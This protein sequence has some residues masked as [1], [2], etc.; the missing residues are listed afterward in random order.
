MGLSDPFSTTYEGARQ[1][2]GTIGG[3]FQQ[4]AQNI[5]ERK[6]KDR[7]FQQKAQL[8]EQEARIKQQYPSPWEAMMMASLPK[9]EQ[10]NVNLAGL[11]GP[12]GMKTSIGKGGIS[13]TTASP[14]KTERELEQSREL[15]KKLPEMSDNPTPEE[16]KNY[17]SELEKLEPETA[18]VVQGLGEFDYGP[19]DIGGVLTGR[20]HALALTK[21]AYGKNWSMPDYK[22]IYQT[23]QDIRPGGNIGQAKTS[24]NMLVG[25][26]DQLYE[27]MRSLQNVDI[28]GANRLI[29]WAKYEAGKKEVQS[30]LTNALPVALE[31]EKYLKG[32]GVT[33]QEG[34][35]EWLQRI[36]IDGS[37]AQ[38]KAWLGQLNKL[39]ASRTR[40]LETN[41]NSVIGKTGRK[42]EVLDDYSKKTLDKHGIPH[43]DLSPA[44]QDASMP[45]EDDIQETL[46]KHPEYTRESLLQKLRGK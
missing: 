21:K 33:S 45:S 1:G 10:G 4:I 43:G 18:A 2:L 11:G 24:L 28:R 16:T 29:N 14:D 7:E 36:P 30:A 31:S 26:L 35:D 25:H 38:Q 15:F 37:P 23:L 20:K 27:S 5:A 46:Q 13:M 19:Q 39:F 34:V 41:V 6:Q 22:Q 9:D 12:S 32:S 17:L 3:G 44:S 40:A 42:W 8:A